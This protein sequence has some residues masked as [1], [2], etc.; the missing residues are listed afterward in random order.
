MPAVG[1]HDHL[2]TVYGMIVAMIG[3]RGEICC[4]LGSERGIGRS[5]LGFRPTGSGAPRRTLATTALVA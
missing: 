4:A 3:A 1:W 2:F 5:A